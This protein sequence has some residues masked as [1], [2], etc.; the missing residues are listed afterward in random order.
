MVVG[1]E[2]AVLGGDEAG[3][4]ARSR[5]RLLLKLS[6]ASVVRLN[7]G[8]R[9]KSKPPSENIPSS[10]LFS[11]LGVLDHCILLVKL[12]AADPVEALEVEPASP[13]DANTV[14]DHRGFQVQLQ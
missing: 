5:L 10:H 9:R 12:E 6:Q 14:Q 8:R 4:V 1:L 7:L 3:E 2:L 13:P 11:K